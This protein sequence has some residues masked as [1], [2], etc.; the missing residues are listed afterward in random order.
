MAIEIKEL[1][2]KVVVS[3]ASRSGERHTAEL[4]AQSRK[5]IIKECVDQVMERLEWKFDR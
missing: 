1:K 4:S 5:Q 3:E 2:I